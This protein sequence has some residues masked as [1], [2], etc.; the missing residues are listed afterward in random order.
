MEHLGRWPQGPD[1]I[2]PLLTLLFGVPQHPALLF[3]VLCRGC[4]YIM[5]S[6]PY[7]SGVGWV[8]ISPPHQECSVPCP[9]WRPPVWNGTIKRGL[10]GG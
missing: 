3:G 7:S 5:Y 6:W 4:D 10:R 9:P 1:G 8:R 2:N